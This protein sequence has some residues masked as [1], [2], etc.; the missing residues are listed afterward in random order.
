M[1]FL[2]ENEAPKQISLKCIFVRKASDCAKVGHSLSLVA[3]DVSSDGVVHVGDRVDLAGT[4]HIDIALCQV[5]M[6]YH[7]MWYYITLYHIIACYCVCM[8]VYMNT[9]YI[10]IYMMYT[11]IY[12][13]THTRV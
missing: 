6:L 13:Y 12:I 5:S 8:C 1:S 9:I 3:A 11:Y 10:Y 4:Y 7:Y 2:E